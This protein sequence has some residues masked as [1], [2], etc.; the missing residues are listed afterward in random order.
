LGEKAWASRI[1]PAQLATVSA[2]PENAFRVA[3]PLLIV[4]FVKSAS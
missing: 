1:D 2:A 3:S 4:A